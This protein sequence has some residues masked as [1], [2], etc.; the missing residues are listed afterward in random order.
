MNLGLNYKIDWDLGLNVNYNMDIYL[1][2]HGDWTT[3]EGFQTPSN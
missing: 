1:M 3:K 2:A